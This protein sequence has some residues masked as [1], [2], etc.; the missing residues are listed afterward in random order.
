MSRR[1]LACSQ[2]RVFIRLASGLDASRIQMQKFAPEIGRLGER[3]V[4]NSEK[5][6]ASRSLGWSVGGWSVGGWLVRTLHQSRYE[7]VLYSVRRSP[8]V[9]V[10]RRLCAEQSGVNRLWNVTATPIPVAW[11][12]AG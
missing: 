3:L 5:I 7:G 12:E 9:C 6:E 8:T 1:G 4:R 10:L 11:A 2:A